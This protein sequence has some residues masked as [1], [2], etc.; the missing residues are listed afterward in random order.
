[1][2]TLKKDSI[3]EKLQVVVRKTIGGVR[4]FEDHCGET[5]KGLNYRTTTGATEHTLPCDQRWHKSSILVIGERNSTK[6]HKN[7]R[8]T[9]DPP[10]TLALYFF[11]GPINV[12]L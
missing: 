8:I 1:M 7:K 3:T 2:V 5:E 10:P 4:A 12:R 9:S 11:L 6:L